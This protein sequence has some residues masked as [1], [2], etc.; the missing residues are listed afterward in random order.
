MLDDK[1]WQQ[2]SKTQKETFASAVYKKDT[3]QFTKYILN[4]QDNVPS[5][6]RVTNHQRLTQFAKSEKA[7][8]TETLLIEVHEKLDRAIVKFKFGLENSKADLAARHELTQGQVDRLIEARN[9]AKML[10]EEQLKKV[11]ELR[12]MYSAASIAE[13]QK[14]VASVL[15]QLGEVRLDYKFSIPLKNDAE[16][17]ELILYSTLLGDQQ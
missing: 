14:L 17:V 5:G 16:E 3:D 4:L 6:Q 12:K 15:K 9:S 7:D 8:G 2:D 11:E 10:M 13:N 1:L